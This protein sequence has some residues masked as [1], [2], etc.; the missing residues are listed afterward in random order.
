MRVS[1]HVHSL[2]ARFEIEM[3]SG[4]RIQRFV[5]S[6]VIE[7]ERLTVVDTAV[8]SAA[9]AI[10]A[11]IESLGRRPEEIEY[12]INTHGHFDHIG[13]NGVFAERASPRFLAH[14]LDRAI[15]EDLEYQE[16]TRPVGRMREQNTSGPVEVGQLLEEGDTLDLGGGVRVEVL[17]TPGHSPGSL[18][19]LI[20]GDGALMCGDVLPE[21]GALPIYE[22][23]AATL[24]SLDK[25]RAIDGAKVLLSQL[26]ERVW[27]GE[28]VAT[29]IEDG[30]AYLRRI[31]ALIRRAGDE[32]GEG[33]L[34]GD[35]KRWVLAGLGLPEAGL[36]PIV[37]TSFAAHFAIGPLDGIP[38]GAGD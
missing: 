22:D 36:I 24:A 12:V 23:I 9:P 27:R 31:D 37:Q 16:R 6:Y 4:A 18:S 19:L 32:L 13:G 10:F 15:I 14:R 1:S 29:H 26:S 2:L 17:H 28:E 35:I 21:P 33:A 11:Y 8:K 34:A 3:P 25:L 38:G 5:P 7:A 20:P 30:E